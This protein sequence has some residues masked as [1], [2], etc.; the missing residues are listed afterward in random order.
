M[1]K[2]KKYD[3]PGYYILMISVHGLIRSHNLE[4]GR[5]ADTGGQ[6]K[7]VVEEATALASLPSVGRVDLVTRV[8]ED[9]RVSGDYSQVTEPISDKARI[10]RISCGVRRYVRKEKLWPYLD[11]FAD[12]IAKYLRTVG[13][14]PDLIHAHYA[15]AG[16]VGARVAALLDVPLA[17]TGHS[18]GK[19]KKLG[20]TERGV[21]AED[22]ER[23]Y[24]LDTRID[25][26]EQALQNA[27]MVV[28]STHQ[29]VE[30]QYGLYDHY[31][32]NRMQV[33]PPGVDLSR[34]A[35]PGRWWQESFEL[36]GEVDRF[37]RE[38]KK[39][40]ILCVARAD[41]KKNMAALL[42]A[43]GK[44]EKLQEAANLIIVAGNRDDYRKLPRG[45]KDSIKEIIHL[46]DYY[47]L[48]GKVAFPKRHSQ[49]E[50][51]LL[52]RHAAHS[53]GVFVNP[54]WN[55][56]FGLTLLEAAA[57]GLPVV[58]TNEGGP[59]DII[60]KLSNG[61]L[62]DPSDPEMIEEAIGRI[63]TDRKMWNSYSRQGLVA[64]DRHYSWKTHAKAY[65]KVARKVITSDSRPMGR[66]LHRRLVSHDRMLI[67]DIDNTLTGDR[68]ALARLM[69]MLL[70]SSDKV[71]FGV[72]SGRSLDL[73]LEALA[74]WGIA[75]PNALIT[76]VGTEIHYGPNLVRDWGYS[77]HLNYRWKPDGI[78]ETLDQL[79]GLKLQPPDGQGVH[80]ISYFIDPETAPTRAEIVRLLRRAGLSVS[81]IY[82][83]GAFLDILPSRA[84][85]GQAIRRLAS[86]W[87][88]PLERIMVAGDSGN[89][90]EMLVGEMQ[91]V[92]VGNYSPELKKLRKRPKIYFA[93]GRYANGV[94]EAVEKFRWFDDDWLATETR[95]VR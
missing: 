95:D 7:Y 87:E 18:L 89:D 33:I 77:T 92:V 32:P 72:A 3:K 78:H 14:A 13:R 42:H 81:V 17:F 90:E 76:G 10:A 40:M 21:V 11:I 28:C 29:E 93:Q 48:Y 66:T 44:S 6:V 20:L 52:Y 88:I 63:V 75:M 8:L 73:T 2:M 30:E 27:A 15:D 41:K 61:E 49:E 24:S 56:P 84:S 23:E 82:S 38:P 58:A 86:R 83:H 25:A 31:Q 68:K 5:D 4:L 22:M 51:P 67:C 57:S 65:M 50:I 69:R 47:D 36:K 53:R 80:K 64:V 46:I 39:P 74:K 70:D 35:P 94:I 1:E 62:V 91:G 16:Y 19:V 85:K 45:Q 37:L 79:P 12:N 26:E 59:V 71:G 9:N 55:E 34:F 60:Q 43:Y 54:A